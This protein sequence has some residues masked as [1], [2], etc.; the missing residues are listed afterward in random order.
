MSLLF[1][2]KNET[3]MDLAGLQLVETP[4]AKGSKHHPYSFADFA[5]TLVDILPA[6]DL[7]PIDS[8]FA[9]SND[10]MKFF[11]TVE[12]ETPMNDISWQ[13]GVRG[14]HDQSIARGLV[15]GE[16]VMVC[17][18]LMFSGEIQ[19]KTKQTTKIEDRVE[20]MLIDAVLQM[21]GFFA[22]EEEMLERLRNERVS[23]IQ[24]DAAF[25]EIFRKGGLTG[26]QLTEAIR[27]WENPTFDHGEHDSIWHI[28]QCATQA[29]KPVNGVGNT[30]LLVDRSRKV[31][32]TLVEMFDLAA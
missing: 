25:V 8:Q 12:V 20:G 6:V 30:N 29:L 22:V 17:S 7:K 18:N 14:S 9:V 11:G 32:S 1:N 4:P 3:L 19:M 21:P 13:I 2:S 24:A 23:Q 28:E 27:Q 5:N 16:R 31:R 10:G 15:A 26:N